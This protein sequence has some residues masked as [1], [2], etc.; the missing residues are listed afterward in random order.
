MSEARIDAS[1]PRPG[2]YRIR[3][4]RGGPWRAVL[5]RDVT[6]RDPETGELL[7]DQK[8]EALVNDS[9]VSIDR[10]WPWA[11]KN[12]ISDAEYEELLHRA[13]T[14]IGANNPPPDNALDEAAVIAAEACFI[15]EPAKLVDTVKRATWLLGKLDEERKDAVAEKRAEIA[16]VELPYRQAHADLASAKAVMM[17]EIVKLFR[18][19]PIRGDTAQAVKRTVKK[20]EITDATK[21]PREFLVPDADLIEAALK[22]GAVIDGAVLKEVQTVVVT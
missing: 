11:A 4:E 6:E 17:A 2:K 14:G 22:K 10:V 15:T 3:T 21:I 19:E 8:W 5:I 20:L 7:E 18:G 16:A 12:P 13:R 9:L 1:I